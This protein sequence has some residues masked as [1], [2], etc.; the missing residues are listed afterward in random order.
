MKTMDRIWNQHTIERKLKEQEILSEL[1]EQTTLKGFGYMGR[2]IKEY[3]PKECRKVSR[4]KVRVRIKRR[5][6]EGVRVRRKKE[7][8]FQENGAGV[9][10]CCE[11]TNHYIMQRS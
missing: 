3:L 7:F 1:V 10:D 6:T 5:Q 4:L 8:S 9:Y 11:Y 2:G